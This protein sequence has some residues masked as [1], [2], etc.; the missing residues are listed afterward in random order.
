M[1]LIK[2]A[3]NMSVGL[4]ALNEIGEVFRQSNA[5]NKLFLIMGPTTR[6][7]S[8]DAVAGRLTKEG[9]NVVT[10]V[11]EGGAT[12][13]NAEDALRRVKESGAEG[14]VGVGGGSI[15]DIVKYVGFKLDL[16]TISIPTTLSSD[17]IA[18]PF[19]VLWKE[20]KSHAV[21]TKSPNLVIGDY[22]VLMKEP[23]KFVAAGFGDMVAKY[24]ALF[25]WRL[26]YW[27]GDE[28]YLDFAAQLAESILNLLL[29]RVK[30]VAAQNYI[31][32]ETLFYAEVMDGYL[33]ELANTTR[34]AAGSE[35]LI[36]F[37]IEHVAGKGMH[38]E[39]VGLGTIISAY[40]QNRD[41]R[42]VR[43]ALETVGAPTTAD[44]LGLSKEE[45][46]KALQIAH[47]MRNWYTILGDRGL[48]AG[49]AERLLRY[50]KII[51]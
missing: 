6:K 17:A 16:F 25:D 43:E 15:I 8:G 47:Q 27:L 48:S 49:K 4:G 38:G 14:I 34:V 31:G 39:Q 45:L 20:G 41:W 44:E 42:M 46:I 11:I 18:S 9:Y 10:H 3:T 36:A 19:S 40:L 12:F 7:L 13:D 37:A 22:D 21:R 28:P 5:P 33:M 24:T 35:H 26:A 1:R 30:D 23:H 51:G 29:R 50:T 2:L 32:I